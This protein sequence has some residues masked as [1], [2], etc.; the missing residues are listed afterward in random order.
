MF[1]SAA[2]SRSSRPVTKQARLI[3]WVPM[4]ATVPPGPERAGSVRQSACFCPVC[5][6]GVASQSCGYSTCTT[7]S[8]PSRPSATMA[9]ASR[10]IG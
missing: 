5:S 1:T 10:T 7:R 8:R 3:A 9:L 4:S 2:S 6:S